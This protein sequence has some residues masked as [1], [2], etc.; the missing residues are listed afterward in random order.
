M[1]TLYIPS[2]WWT[3]EGWENFLLRKQFAP[4]PSYQ[5]EVICSSAFNWPTK[6]LYKNSISYKNGPS[7]S[8]FAFIFRLFNR[9]DPSRKRCLDS[10]SRHLEYQSPITTRP[11]LPPNN[12]RSYYRQWIILVSLYP[13]HILEGAQPSL[14]EITEAGDG[15]W[16][17]YS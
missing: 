12:A 11:G 14:I 10:N 3:W 16:L 15:Q 4:P 6:G 8:S 2:L 7:L 9:H 5:F 17:W 13:Y 1:R